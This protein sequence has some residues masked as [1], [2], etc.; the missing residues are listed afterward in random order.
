MASIEDFIVVKPVVKAPG[1]KSVPRTAS[2]FL[3][4]DSIPSP[5][6]L[7]TSNDDNREARA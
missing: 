5:N 1:G 6:S 3:N 4:L 2:K 7:A